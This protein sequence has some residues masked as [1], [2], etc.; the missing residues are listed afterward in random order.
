MAQSSMTQS[1]TQWITETSWVSFPGP[2]TGG[3][4]SSHLS[5]ISCC[6]SA[7]HLQP[8][9]PCG[10]DHQRLTSSPTPR[11]TMTKTGAF[12]MEIKRKETSQS[13]KQKNR[14][15]QE[16]RNVER[17]PVMDPW[18]PFCSFFSSF[19]PTVSRFRPL[20]VTL[21]FLPQDLQPGG[22]T[23]I[24][25]EDTD[26]S[27]DSH[28][29]TWFGQRHLTTGRRLPTPSFRF[30]G[31]QQRRSELKFNDGW[32]IWYN[33]YCVSEIFHGKRANLTHLQDSDANRRDGCEV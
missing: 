20:T 27:S 24:L 15:C 6:P 5:L 17:K 23:R 18:G 25:S 30:V 28:I 11:R 10:P 19:C 7:H 26:L 16:G 12:Q 1:F 21:L 31:K 33:Y 13:S 32:F 3:A 8:L 29:P 9:Q 14:S 22:G 4:L 2:T